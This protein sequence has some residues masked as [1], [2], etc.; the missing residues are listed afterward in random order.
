[1]NNNIFSL[2]RDYIMQVKS[3]TLHLETLALKNLEIS[4]LTLIQ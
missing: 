3:N 2:N 1:M 4:H